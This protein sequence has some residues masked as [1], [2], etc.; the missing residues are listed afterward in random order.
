MILSLPWYI[1]IIL[2]HTVTLLLVSKWL[3]KTLTLTSI[4]FV[5]NQILQIS[6]SVGPISRVDDTQARLSSS[7]RP[8]SKRIDQCSSESVEDIAYI[9]E[10]FGFQTSHDHWHSLAQFSACM[11]WAHSVLYY[12][13]NMIQNDVKVII[14]FLL[15]TS[16][17][18]RAGASRLLHFVICEGFHC[19]SSNLKSSTT[20]LEKFDLKIDDC[21]YATLPSYW[22]F[23]KT[24][25]RPYFI[26]FCSH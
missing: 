23:F 7:I 13:Y 12:R 15:P 25:R 5:I 24:F 19:A 10:R 14:D 2:S 21:F 3:K 22:S 20:M 1:N 6:A 16:R 9:S 18:Y 26:C 17:Q 4:I 11:P 8:N